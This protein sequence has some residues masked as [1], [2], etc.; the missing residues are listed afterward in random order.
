MPKWNLEE[1]WVFIY[2]RVLLLFVCLGI[3]ASACAETSQPLVDTPAPPTLTSVPS[4]S[5]LDTPLPVEITVSPSITPT[6]KVDVTPTQTTKPLEPPPVPMQ[7]F[8]TQQYS[9]AVMIPLGWTESLGK[10][11]RCGPQAEA[12]WVSEDN[13]VLTIVE[14]DTGDVGG[15]GLTVQQYVDIIL[16]DRS[17]STPQFELLSNRQ[18]TTETGL[19]TTIL[20]FTFQEGFVKGNEQ[21]YAYEGN[22]I[23]VAYLTFTDEF[24]DLQ[25]IA[26]F[27]FRHL[28][29]DGQE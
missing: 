26:D 19:I 7:I 11:Q 13:Q 27:S 21:Y 22:M 5:E 18:L 15:S 28:A 6:E 23:I 4:T 2:S 20:E 10:D 8:T 17:E 9:Y 16:P 1:P 12:C 24:I 25:P 3:I 29:V 14:F